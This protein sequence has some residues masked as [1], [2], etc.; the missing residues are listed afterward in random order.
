MFVPPLTALFLGTQMIVTVADE[1]PKLHIAATC[2]A[3][4]ANVQ[5]NTQACLRD[6]QSAHDQLLQQ[7]TTLASSDRADCS[8]TTES[9]GSSSYIE[10]LTCLQLARDAR[11]LPRN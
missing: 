5:S 4:S 9:G 10:L 3:E 7:W 8:Q 11:R 2:R 6:E 1:V